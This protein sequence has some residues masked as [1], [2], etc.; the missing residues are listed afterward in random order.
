M[1]F[2][3]FA[4]LLINYKGL[5]MDEIWCYSF[6]KRIAEG[7]IPYKDYNIIL[8][9]LFF[10]IGALFSN[11]L[12]LFR[13]YGAFISSAVVLL[14]FC[15]CYKN[16]VDKQ[17]SI[18]IALINCILMQVVVFANYNIMLLLGL[19]ILYL[20][21]NRF[22]EKVNTLNSF[23]FGFL[24]SVVLFIKQNVPAFLIV[25]FTCLLLIL[26]LKR[27]IV[28]KVFFSYMLGGIMPV[29]I[30]VFYTIR[31]NCLAAFIDYTILG[32]HSFSENYLIQ[33]GSY[34]LIILPVLIT[35]FIFIR[36]FKS[37]N[38]K[39]IYLNALIFSLSSYML[40]YPLVD[41]YHCLLLLVFNITLSSIILK[42]TIIHFNIIKYALIISL[43]ILCCIK[44]FPD[45]K[46]TREGFVRSKISPYNNILLSKDAEENLFEISRFIMY[47]ENQGLDVAIIDGS[48]YFYNIPAHDYNGVLDL[49]SMGNMGTI[50]NDKIISL[51]NRKDMILTNE[52]YRWHDIKEVREYVFNNYIQEETV[53]NMKIY[54]KP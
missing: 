39:L 44:A 50:S 33:D 8:T 49:I 12:I 20:A 47:Q 1:L 9:P 15:I 31:N 24:L 28:I 7:Y 5:S 29:I 52:I 48:A 40:I 16:R 22:F 10:Y 18:I 32:M 26:V 6:S 2:V 30:F 54:R 25:I 13:I 34:L 38:H 45:L 17:L 51:I 46:P 11:S 41:I 36:F 37:K 43:I 3:F 14:S 21:A 27:I 19:M 4:I 53:G 42:D 35:I 23:L